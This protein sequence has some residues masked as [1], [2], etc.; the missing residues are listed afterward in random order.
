MFNWTDP[1]S[2][3]VMSLV[4]GSVAAETAKSGSVA[5]YSFLSAL[6]SSKSKYLV[7]VSSDLVAF[8]CA[9]VEA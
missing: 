5:V 4:E 2:S 7:A 6:R 8:P 9:S 1:P 3:C